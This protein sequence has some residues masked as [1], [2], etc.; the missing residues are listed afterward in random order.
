MFALS[1]I[2]CTGQFKN[3]KKG[4]IKL[5]K[6]DNTFESLLFFIFNLDDMYLLIQ[7][8]INKLPSNI[9][10]MLV[11]KY[12]VICIVTSFLFSYELRFDQFYLKEDLLLSVLYK[13]IIIIPVQGI[14]FYFMGLYKGIWRFSS[15][16]DLLRII[17]AVTI[18][19]PCSF[20]FLFLFKEINNFPRSIFFMQ[21][22]LLIIFIGGG[23]F[24][25]RL[26][27]DFI[28]DRSN[29]D[30]MR[31]KRTLIIGAG[32][33]SQILIRDI[34]NDLSSDI[35]IVGLLDDDIN[36]RNKILHGIKVLG[37][38]SDI[39][40]IASQ[41]DV[42]NVIIALPKVS[43]K[44]LKR[45]ISYCDDTNLDVRSIPSLV[46]IVSGKLQISKLKKVTPADLLGRDQIQLDKKSMSEMIMEKVILV[47]GAGG[48]I[49]SELCKQIIHFNPSRIICYD[50]SEYNLYELDFKLK[51][52]GK[53]V[54]IQF[55][56]GDVRD[57]YNVNKVFENFCPNL[58]FH[59]AAYK[60]VPMMEKNPY[61]A[62]KVNVVGTKVVA[63]IA[64]KYNLD[65]FVL[66]STD[67]AVN[68]TNVMGATKRIAE[69]VCQEVQKVSKIKFSIVRFGN[70]LGSSGS[71]I[72]RFQ[73]QIEDGGPLTVT[74]PEIIR[75]FMSIPEAAQ[76]VIQAASL[77][78]GGEIF[79]LDMGEPVKIV[80]LAKQMITLAGLKLN[81]DIEIVFSGLRPGEKLFEE[82]LSDKEET[83]ST[84]H[85]RLRIAKVR[86]NIKDIETLILSLLDEN[87]GIAVRDKLRR[88]VP[89]YVPKE[90][91]ND[92]E[93][94]SNVIK[95]V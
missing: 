22:S 94:S 84:S 46:D 62:I 80:D 75:Y 73:K 33:A 61:E 87:N 7:E 39:A 5:I 71:V 51:Q 58:V 21:W 91:Q 95:F 38:I 89:E 63:N 27:R 64:N 50:I 16:P 28:L 9:K 77:G 70:V 86:N 49:G 76:L 2:F 47:T 68:P 15:T 55:I 41:E 34:K 93:I 69:I 43:K 4:Y 88:I 60:H 6:D 82:L 85:E 74:H 36:K 24:A 20:L 57:E 90:N 52:F 18:A 32:Y 29:S 26:Y 8:I 13:L 42:K 35:R 92:Y 23:R 25:Y 30:K 40:Q 53:V 17:K 11:F 78:T 66:I 56:V 3:L 67:K 19:I 65:R 54:D 81:E 12:D 59:A 48:S 31:T 45:I 79:V 44:E 10:S 37:N 14:C 83:I 72:P 1:K